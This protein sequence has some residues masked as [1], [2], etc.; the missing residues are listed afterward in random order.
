[1][2]KLQKIILHP[3]FSYGYVFVVIFCIFSLL[4]LPQG[5]PLITLGVASGLVM[6]ALQRYRKYL[7]KRR[8]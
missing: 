4:A 2:E 8:N 7:L 5:H 6:F 3:Y 1:M